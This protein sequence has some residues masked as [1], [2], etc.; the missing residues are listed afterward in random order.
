MLC[1][2]RRIHTCHAR[3]HKIGVSIELSG[4]TIFTSECRMDE[5]DRE[6]AAGETSIDT[7]TPYTHRFADGGWRFGSVQLS[8]SRSYLIAKTRKDWTVSEMTAC[9]Y[10]AAC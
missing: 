9:K 3:I 5:N 8:F 2:M 6:R 1:H 10:V 4:R 7:N